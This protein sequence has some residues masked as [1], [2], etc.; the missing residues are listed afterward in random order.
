MEDSTVSVPW[1][2]PLSGWTASAVFPG[3]KLHAV[4]PLFRSGTPRTGVHP[5]SDTEH[6]STHCHRCPL[7]RQRLH[8]SLPVFAK[9]IDRGRQAVIEQLHL[10]VRPV[11][12]QN[13][14]LPVA[15]KVRRPLDREAGRRGVGRATA[16]LR[17]HVADIV[18]DIGVVAEAADHR[19]GAG[20][21]VQVI[22][23]GIAGQ[24]V[25]AGKAI[26]VIVEAASGQRIVARGAGQ[27]QRRSRLQAARCEIVRRQLQVAGQLDAEVGHLVAIGVAFQDGD[28]VRG[29]VCRVQRAGRAV[30]GGAAEE[31]E[32]ILAGHRAVGIDAAEIDLVGPDREVGDQVALPGTRAG[33]AIGKRE[34]IGAA[35]AGQGIH[36]GA[37]GEDVVAAVAGDHVV[38]GIAGAVEIAAAGQ[39]QVLHP[40]GQRVV[41]GGQHRVG[42]LVAAAQRLHRIRDVI[43]DTYPIRSYRCSVQVH[44]ELVVRPR[45]DTEH[46]S[47][48]LPSMSVI[49]AR[50][51]PSVPVFAKLIVDVATPLSSSCI[52][53]FVPFVIR[54]S[55]CPSPSKSAVPLIVNPAGGV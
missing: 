4:L 28:V 43:P 42:A 5:R 39:R 45:S 48:P 32:G 16:H 9:L 55:V 24:R 14:G 37:A 15:V 33:I 17:H 52:L 54:T 22:V 3:H 19:V 50:L 11:R 18:D 53:T 41:D 6:P 20:A 7:S 8:P 12:D 34:D 36:A 46:P 31:A 23:A 51:H 30:E 13:V 47:Y 25:V 44:R 21:A 1:L 38:Q 49:P 26:Q 10:D 35:I 40:A 27:G 2:P 29:I